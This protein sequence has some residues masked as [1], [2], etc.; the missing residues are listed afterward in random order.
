MKKGDISSEPCR[1]REGGLGPRQALN[2][3][4][5]QQL[6]SYNRVVFHSNRH[7]SKLAN[8]ARQSIWT[9]LTAPPNDL[10]AYV[11]FPND[12]Q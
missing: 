9:F 10:F 1:I 6:E 3:S 8:N 4:K 12:F 11:G 2:S 7:I 5:V